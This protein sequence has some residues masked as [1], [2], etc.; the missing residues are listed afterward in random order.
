MNEPL[1]FSSHIAA[2]KFGCP[3]CKKQLN[4]LQAEHAEIGWKN[5]CTDPKCDGV[6]EYTVNY[7]MRTVEEPKQQSRKSHPEH[8]AQPAPQVCENWEFV[9]NMYEWMDKD[10][11]VVPIKKLSDKEFVDSVWALIHMNFAKVGPT[12]SWAKQLPSFGT[13]Y[14]YPRE[15]IGVGARDAKEKIEEFYENAGERG[16]VTPE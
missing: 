12:L 4:D 11:K 3:I 1:K 9:A 5:R 8:P 13:A 10:G 15:A 7:E 6:I 14:D 2:A 16:W